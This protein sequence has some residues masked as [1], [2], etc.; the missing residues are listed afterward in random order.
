MTINSKVI[1][2][3]SAIANLWGTLHPFVA[4]LFLFPFVISLMYYIPF[5]RTICNVSVF[6]PELLKRYMECFCILMFLFIIIV[7]FN[8]TYLTNF[9]SNI[10]SFLNSGPNYGQN[11]HWV[12]LVYIYTIF[13]N[14][15][16]L[17]YECNHKLYFP[18]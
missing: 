15:I 8:F 6:L 2:V 9:N 3:T 7:F 16:W 13:R 12:G 11:Y 5:V 4:F 14:E 17:N 18:K 10:K 1:E